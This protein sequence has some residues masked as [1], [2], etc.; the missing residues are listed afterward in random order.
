MFLLI[1]LELAL[2]LIWIGLPVF[3]IY[4]IVV[5][6]RGVEV[7]IFYIKNIPIYYPK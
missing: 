7:N 1:I 3:V 6:S 2:I 5:I 4:Q